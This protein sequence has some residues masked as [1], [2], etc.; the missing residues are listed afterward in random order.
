MPSFVVDSTLKKVRDVAVDRA[1]RCVVHCLR[2]SRGLPFKPGDCPFFSLLMA[3]YASLNVIGVSMAVR[4]GFSLMR[5]RTV[6]STGLCLF[7]TLWK[8]MPKTDMFSLAWDASLLFSRCI[9]MLRL[10]VWWI[11][12]PLVSMRIFSY[13]RRGFIL[14][15]CILPH[16]FLYQLA[17]ASL[18]R[19]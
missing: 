5:S 18:T 15:S 12:S 4:H 10:A 6:E 14:I 3:F 7:G 11:V 13:A 2:A 1:A 9:D 19:S 16:I 17:F 8:C